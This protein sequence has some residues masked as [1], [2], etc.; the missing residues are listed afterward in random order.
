M[1]LR[2]ALGYCRVHCGVD[3]WGGTLG[4]KYFLGHLFYLFEC[5]WYLVNLSSDVLI[6]LTL[7]DTLR[8]L[9]VTD[10]EKL[11]LVYCCCIP[12]YGKCFSAKW[13]LC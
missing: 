7:S 13:G 6:L 9:L 5:F 3:F 1:L 2:K 12:K 11:E 4:L 10:E 8:H